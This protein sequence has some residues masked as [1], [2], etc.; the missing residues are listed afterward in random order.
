MTTNLASVLRRSAASF[1]AKTAV[2]AS[3]TELDYATV[4]TL[5]RMFAGALR[6]LGVRPGEHVALVLPNVPQ[7]TVAYFGCHYAGNPVVPL[8][9]LLT[10]DEL[11]YH[12][13]DSESVAVVAWDLFLPAVQEAA[14]R[15]PGVRRIL[16]ATADLGDLSAPAG[17]DNLTAVVAA[18]TPVDVPH[19]TSPDDTAVVLY[20]SGTTGRAKGAELTHA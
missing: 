14:A 7:F 3:D 13:A 6:D 9:V 11:A 20:T 8:N 10:A 17:T 19:P 16:V 2:V 15:T 18:A 12:L 4:D 5:A 1:P